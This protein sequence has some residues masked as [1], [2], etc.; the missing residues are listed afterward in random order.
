M[1]LLSW[2][3]L[4]SVI[5]R[6]DVVLEV[7]EAR[8]PLI[9]RSIKAE[10]IA[11]SLGKQ[12]IIII[13]KCDL[14]PLWVCKEWQNYFKAQNIETFY[15][16]S[17]TLTGIKK[18]KH[19]LNK[20]IV[21]RPATILLIGYPKV[22]KSSLI[23]ALKGFKSASTS[24]Y[25]GTPGYTKNLTLYKI[26]PGIYIIDTPGI[27]PPEGDDIEMIIRRTP[28][29]K[30]QNPIEIVKKI[31]EMIQKFDK[32]IINAT[33]HIRSIDPIEILKELAIKRGWINKR[34]REPNVDE[35]A[36]TIIRDYLRGKLVYYVLPS[37]FK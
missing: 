26:M 30:I 11:M 1:I 5:N 10:K 22:G 16:S 31:I 35:A 23:N 33:Y 32:N 20:S 37:N 8:N 27:I 6:A 17:L 28:V 14:V 24:P 19:F 21:K 36:R 2:R 4:K 9:T 12:F 15:I 13:N 34:D 25:P 7:V 29:E 3:N 18:L